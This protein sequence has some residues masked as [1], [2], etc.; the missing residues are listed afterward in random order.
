MISLKAEKF[1]EEP[2]TQIRGSNINARDTVG[3][4]YPKP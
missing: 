2:V 1:V 4:S 3:M